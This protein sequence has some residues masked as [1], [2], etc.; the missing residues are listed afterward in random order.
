MRRTVFLLASL[1]LVA[2][3][4]PLFSQEAKLNA[5]MEGA[6]RKPAQ[7]G[8]IFVH[9]EGTP[10]DMG[11]STDTCWPRKLRTRKKW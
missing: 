8:W 4:L 1:A 3:S 5:H 7:N 6:F 2:A 11:F 10:F 9:L